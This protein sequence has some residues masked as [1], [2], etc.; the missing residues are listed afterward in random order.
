[1]TVL[2]NLRGIVSDWLLAMAL[3]AAPR[4]EKAELA[5]AITAYLSRHK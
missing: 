4:T 2:H 1:M 3:S 5:T